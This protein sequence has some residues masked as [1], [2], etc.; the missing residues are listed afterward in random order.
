MPEVEERCTDTLLAELLLNSTDLAA[1]VVHHR[2]SRK[3]S[4]SKMT[5]EEPRKEVH[6]KHQEHD[7]EGL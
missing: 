1:V 4:L 6:G 7:S 5:E 3:G 2:V